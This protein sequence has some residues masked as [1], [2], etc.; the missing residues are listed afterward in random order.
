MHIHL[1]MSNAPR[2]Y[3]RGSYIDIHDN[4]NVYLTVDKNGEVTTRI[5]EAQLKKKPETAAVS[6]PD[7]LRTPEAE[8]LL[9]KL[10]DAGMLERNWQPV[11]I[12]N[13]EKGTLIEYISEKLDIRAKWKF[14]GRLWAI[15]SET[16]RTSKSR[17]L[18]QD[19]T[20]K[21]RERLD[22]L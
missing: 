14:F 3:V 9:K 5:D 22:A 12:S 13:A 16:L 21:F 4:E 6:V 19:K 2:I 1:P 11:G 15:D 17:G 7:V 18:E 20:W 10:C 8:A